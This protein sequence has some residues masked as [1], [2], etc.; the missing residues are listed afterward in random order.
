MT[1]YSRFEPHPAHPCWVLAPATYTRASCRLLAYPPVGHLDPQFLALMDEVQA[2]LRFRLRD[3]ERSDD[4][5]VS[6]TGIGRH[7]GRLSPTL[8]SQATR[9]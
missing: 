5:N 2:L 8:S 1:P 4:R 3:R 6:G 9:C 7:G